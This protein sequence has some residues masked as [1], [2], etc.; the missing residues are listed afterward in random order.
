MSVEG[1]KQKDYYT[2]HPT[3]CPRLLILVTRYPIF[4]LSLG[5]PP[6]TSLGEKERSRFNDTYRS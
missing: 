6:L 4:H 5:T 2:R 1:K 3:L